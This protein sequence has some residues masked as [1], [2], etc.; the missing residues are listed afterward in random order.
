MKLTPELLARA[1]SSINTLS[2]RHLDLRGLKIPSIENLGV[3]RDQND[4]IDFTDNDIRYLGNFPLLSQL[5]HLQLSNNLVARIDPRI[6]FS[7]PGLHSLTLTNNSISDAAEL[8]HLTKCKRLEFLCLMGNPVSREKHY[9]EFVIWKL[10]QVRVLDFQRIK[11]KER[12]LAKEL[13]EDEEGRPSALAV[14]RLG[15]SNGMDA[16]IIGISKDRTFEPGRLNGSQRRLLTAEEKKAIED[17][18]EKSES[19]EEIR[20]LEEQLK[21]GHT[22]V[23]SL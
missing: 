14:S 11:D 5:K 6:G 3:T 4:S 8:S 12:A 10:P 9:R 13:M 2:D 23:G 17:A 18:I 21:M 1:T 22:F 7:L 16:D 15:K 20:R 19:L